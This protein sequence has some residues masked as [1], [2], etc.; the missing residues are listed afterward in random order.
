MAHFAKISENNIVLNVLTL[1]DKDMSDENGNLSELLGQQYLQKH[2]NWPAHLWIQTSYNT[3]NNEHKLNGTPFRGNY[4]G[5]G[6]IWDSVNNI[7]ITS[8]PF[9]SW[10]LNLNK[11]RWES[12]IG[13]KPQLTEEERSQGK[14]YSWNEEILN[15]VLI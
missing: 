11:A 9:N 10:V 7:F 2:N 14:R 3:I 8:K 12:P 5:I 6:Y 1:N 4:A 13:E 15:W